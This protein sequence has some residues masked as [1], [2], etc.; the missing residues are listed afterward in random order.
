MLNNLEPLFCSVDDFCQCFESEWKK[1]LLSSGQVKRDR[2]IHL[3]LGEILTILIHFHH[4][5]FRNFK[6]YYEFLE[7]YR[8]QDYPHLVSYQRFVALMPRALIPLCV[9]LNYR[10]GTMTGIQFIDSTAIAV[11]KAKRI[12][13]N[14]VFKE[15]ARVGKSSMGWFFGFKLHLI[16]NEVGELLAFRITAANIDDRLPVMDL[17]EK[18]TGK[19]FGDKGY[20]SQKLFEDLLKN[21]LHLVTGIRKNMKNKLMPLVD[22]LLLRKR[23]L[24]ETVNDELKNIC[25]IEHSRHRSVFNFMVNLVAGL[26]AYTHLEKKPALNFDLRPFRKQLAELPPMAL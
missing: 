14:H 17:S 20:I 2:S 5:G 15:V 1:Q 13:R 21:G 25:Q 9:Y 19:L 3:C 10:R 7:H 23:S 4:S 24:I 11:C 6:H 12:R 26:A 18:L 8:K 22:K 16:I